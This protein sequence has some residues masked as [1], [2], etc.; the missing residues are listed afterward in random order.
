MSLFLASL[1]EKGLASFKQIMSHIKGVK[2][3]EE[4]IDKTVVPSRASADGL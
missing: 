1:H 2:L 4:K 3:V